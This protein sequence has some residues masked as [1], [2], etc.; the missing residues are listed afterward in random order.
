MLK[1]M[2]FENRLLT[3]DIM[4]IEEGKTAKWEVPNVK[5]VLFIV[6][7]VNDILDTIQVSIKGLD[8]MI[9]MQVGGTTLSNI[10][11][12]NSDVFNQS[13]ELKHAVSIFNK[14]TFD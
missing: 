5:C 13:E 8:K 7:R 11:L 9:Y 14:T 12:G 4:S 6:W 1:D 3:L 10:L 2:F